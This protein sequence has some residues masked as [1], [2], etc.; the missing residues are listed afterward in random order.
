MLTDDEINL[1]C[2]F[3]LEPV[4]S[5]IDEGKRRVTITEAVR[6]CSPVY[7]EYIRQPM[8]MDETYDTAVPHS[9]DKSP[10][11]CFF[12]KSPGP[13]SPGLPGFLCDPSPPCLPGGL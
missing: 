2:P 11:P 1:V 9:P 8:T 12:L 7:L 3:L 5:G 13:S 4:E 6:G 10:L